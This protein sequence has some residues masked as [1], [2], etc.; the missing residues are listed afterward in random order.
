MP[1]RR[2]DIQQ[3]GDLAFETWGRLTGLEFMMRSLYAKWALEH[4]DPSV[5]LDAAEQS[6]LNGLAKQGRDDDPV[7]ALLI[8][9]AEAQIRGTI[10]N[11]KRRVSADK[12]I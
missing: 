9:Y 6:L 8:H 10:E 5:F 2:R 4:D 7:E 3:V 11:T 12:Q 1:Y